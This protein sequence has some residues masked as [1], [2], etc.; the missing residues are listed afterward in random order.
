[1]RCLA[2]SPNG[3]QGAYNGPHGR[4]RPPRLL[5]NSAVAT[6]GEV[7]STSANYWLYTGEQFDAKA[8][9]TQGLYYLRARYYDPSIG[10]F[11]TKDPL[12][13]IS[14][15]TYVWNDPVNLV[16]PLG[17]CGWTDPWDCVPVPPIPP[18]PVPIGPIG[19]VPTAVGCGISS[20]C[21]SDVLDWVDTV[22]DHPS[23]VIQQTA[24]TAVA[25]FSSGD[26]SR[27]NGVTF[28]ENCWGACWFLKFTDAYA[29]TL[30]H[31]VFAEGPI[32]PEL[33]RHELTHVRQGDEYGL[34]WPLAY[35]WEMRHGYKCNRFEEEA[36]AAAGQPLQCEAPK[37]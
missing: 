13:G 22:A 30:G 12:P 25:I 1:V 8:R 18:P 20:E 7:R 37:E 5:R 26:V 3:R 31:N 6:F 17:L 14:L 19:L 35:L 9:P 32:Y 15:Y 11:L 24:G 28:Y 21:R 27:E 10:R 33:K 23:S 29:I 4:Q 36:R 16:D 34:L 2:P